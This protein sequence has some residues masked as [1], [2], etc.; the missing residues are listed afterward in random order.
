MRASST[1]IGWWK[2]YTDVGL[3]AIEAVPIIIF[4]LRPKHRARCLYYVIVFSV[5]LT[6]MNVTKL[7]YGDPRPYWVSSDVMGFKTS[8]SFGNP[9]GHSMTSMACAM[10]LWLDFD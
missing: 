9:S 5:I 1:E 4:Y 8:S 10:V 6:V 7:S 2:F 3:I